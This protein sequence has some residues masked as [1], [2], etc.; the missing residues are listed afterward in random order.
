ML[1]SVTEGKAGSVE[2]LETTEQPT[3]VGVGAPIGAGYL[4]GPGGALAELLFQYNPIDHKSS[5]SASLTSS[6]LWLGHR[7]ML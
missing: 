7:F 3:K 6:T 5:G 2:L 4:I 1:E